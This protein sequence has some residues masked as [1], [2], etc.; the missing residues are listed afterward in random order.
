MRL[1]RG[2]QQATHLARVAEETTCLVSAAVCSLPALRQL[3]VCL[4]L[5]GSCLFKYLIS[6]FS[7]KPEHLNEVGTLSST[8]ISELTRGQTG[9]IQS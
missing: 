6:I 1:L 7:R 8:V 9:Q 2:E 3:G 5:L 4:C